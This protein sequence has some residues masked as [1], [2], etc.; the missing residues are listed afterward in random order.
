MARAQQGAEQ[1][2]F[3]CCIFDDFVSNSSVRVYYVICY[4]CYVNKG[5]FVHVKVRR[6]YAVESTGP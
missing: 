5:K 6:A 4:V 1:T 2:Q 3:I